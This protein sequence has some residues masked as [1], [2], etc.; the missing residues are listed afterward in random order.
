MAD[1]YGVQIFE[2][3]IEFL[4]SNREN[5]KADKIDGH[6][7]FDYP[8]YGGLPKRIS[9]KL[10]SEVVDRMQELLYDLDY[11]FQNKLRFRKLMRESLFLLA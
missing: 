3:M 4:W 9:N 6:Y 2:D 11:L 5:L 8:N 1:K 10:S 7:Y